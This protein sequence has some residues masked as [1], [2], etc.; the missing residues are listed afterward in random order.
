M[1]LE[2][3]GLIDFV[4]NVDF[5]KDYKTRMELIILSFL[6][7]PKRRNIQFYTGFV[8]FCDIVNFHKID[9]LF[10]ASKLPTTNFLKIEKTTVKHSKV[11]KSD[12]PLKLPQIHNH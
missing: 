4:Q 11:H 1:I 12:P 9:I 6:Q 7:P 3:R 5:K 10:V 2:P 8:S